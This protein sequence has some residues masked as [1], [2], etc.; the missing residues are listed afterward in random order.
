MLH[1]PSVPVFIDGRAGSVYADAVTRAYFTLAE[2]RR[3]SRQVLATPQID[4]VL[5]ESG[6]PLASALA[7]GPSPGALR[8][9]TR[10][11]R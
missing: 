3:G 5:V 4:A 2:A 10:A 8:T 6:G 1:A 11:R 9:S 7:S